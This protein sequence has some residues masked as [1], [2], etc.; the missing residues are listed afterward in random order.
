MRL[1]DIA[2]MPVPVRSVDTKHASHAAG[3][4]DFGDILENDG[5]NGRDPGTVSGED[6]IANVDCLGGKFDSDPVTIDRPIENSFGGTNLPTDKTDESPPSKPLRMLDH[7]GMDWLALRM[8]RHETSGNDGEV[9]PADQVMRHDLAELAASPIPPGD[10]AIDGDGS[11]ADRQIAAQ[12]ARRDATMT[13]DRTRGRQTTGGQAAAENLATARPQTSEPRTSV[14]VEP[15]DDRRT[16]TRIQAAM[17]RLDSRTDANAV[18]QSSPPIGSVS[19][20]TIP[21]PSLEL[22]TPTRTVLAALSEQAP[23]LA[24]P[25][26]ATAIQQ[27]TTEPMRI[28]RIQLHPLELGMV[29]ARLSLQGGAMAVELQTETRD[30]A[31]RLAADSNDIVKALRGLGIEVERVTVTQSSSSATQ[32]ADQQPGSLDRNERFTDDAADREST[33][34]QGKGAGRGETG[35]IEDRDIRAAP[36]RNGVFI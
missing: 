15:I 35:Q 12:P 29:T 8:P 2:A 11:N 22:Q 33:R 32:Q 23:E 5:L 28:L 34:E 26:A 27:Q 36:D 30:A 14:S 6:Q 4:R 13:D 31:T 1:N 9:S 21:A 3:E 7:M 20:Q 19:V 18:H 25:A 16:T 17:E 10:S 24:R